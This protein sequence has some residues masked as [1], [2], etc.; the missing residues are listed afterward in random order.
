MKRRFPTLRLVFALC[1]IVMLT[2]SKVSGQD[3]NY[4][5]AVAHATQIIKTKILPEYETKE[6]FKVKPMDI[7]YNNDPTIAKYLDEFGSIWKRLDP[8]VASGYTAIQ[9]KVN[10]ET[11]PD[12]NKYRRLL[13]DAFNRAIEL[14]RWR[15]GIGTA[16]YLR[17][18]ATGV[19]HC[20]PGSRQSRSC[21]GPEICVAADAR[22]LQWG[23][24]LRVAKLRVCSTS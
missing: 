18:G 24:V 6:G 11:R 8:V 3:A 23:V 2:I 9:R 21:A 1:A 5:K 19:G 12:A 22:I 20:P 13:A 10:E 7:K 14:A 17:P 15:L 16:G 4:E